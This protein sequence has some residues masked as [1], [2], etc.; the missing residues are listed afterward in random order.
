M[1]DFIGDVGWLDFMGLYWFCFMEDEE[2]YRLGMV[3]VGLGVEN[4]VV[5]EF[6]FI[7]DGVLVMFVE[8]W[9]VLLDC[10]EVVLVF[11]VEFSLEGE[12][13]VDGEVYFFWIEGLEDLLMR[14]FVEVC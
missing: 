3:I 13:L 1:F 12:V 6:C 9:I 4:C 14:C 7:F 10:F 5:F 11:G 2:G 8:F